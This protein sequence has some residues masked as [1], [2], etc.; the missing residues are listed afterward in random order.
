[1]KET[2]AQG[3]C[4]GCGTTLRSRPNP[5]SCPSC[6]VDPRTGGTPARG[7]PSY[8]APRTDPLRA[9]V[10][11]AAL[12][13]LGVAILIAAWVITQPGLPTQLLDRTSQGGRI[14]LWLLFLVSCG[15]VLCGSAEILLGRTLRDAWKGRN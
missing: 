6:G 9:R 10:H 7:F 5:E 13:A 15:C 12:L 14:A 1:M 4:R 3:W 11:G 2:G 8:V